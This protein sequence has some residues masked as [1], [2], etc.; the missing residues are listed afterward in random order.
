MICQDQKTFDFMQCS[1]DPSIVIH[2]F[3]MTATHTKAV[4]TLTS[5]DGLIL[6]ENSG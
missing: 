6:Q 5:S 2:L 1:D 3:V 4:G